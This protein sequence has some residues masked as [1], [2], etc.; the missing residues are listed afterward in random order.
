MHTVVTP[1]GRSLEV[2]EEGAPAGLPVVVHHGT[3]MSG[4]QYPPHVELAREQSLRLLGYDRPGYGGSSRAP[5][6][7]V[8]DC[9]ADVAAIADALGLERYVTWGIS[10]GGPH[11]LAC[12]ALAD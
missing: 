1:D 7:I 8:A 6:R 5:G 10:G 9:A 3:P 12:A 2:H 4:L 11:A